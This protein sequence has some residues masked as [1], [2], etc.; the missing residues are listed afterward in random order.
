MIDCFKRGELT[1][2]CQSAAVP[3]LLKKGDLALLKNWRPVAHL[4]TGYKILSRALSNRLRQHID[5][6]VHMDQSYC[7]PGWTIMDRLFLLRN[8]IDICNLLN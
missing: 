5:L 6:L 7:I 3:L 1:A 2:S 4:C 8:V